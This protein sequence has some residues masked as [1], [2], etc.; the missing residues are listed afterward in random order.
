M[1]FVA[2]AAVAMAVVFC[3]AP[4][5]SGEQ[6]KAPRSRTRAVVLDSEARPLQVERAPGGVDLFVRD[7]GG[8]IRAT[9]SRGPDGKPWL[10]DDSGRALSPLRDE[11]RDLSE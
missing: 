9:I 8:R 4:E 11:D 2:V 10:Y 7:L 3:C 1:R 5:A 6:Q